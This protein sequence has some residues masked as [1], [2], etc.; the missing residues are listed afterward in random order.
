MKKGLIFFVV[1][2]IFAGYLFAGDGQ[3]SFPEYFMVI[4][5][6]L[7][8]SII[9]FVKQKVPKKWRWVIAYFL[10]ALVGVIGMFLNK[11][12]VLDFQDVQAFIGIGFLYTQLAYKLIWFKLDKEK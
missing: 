12:P 3:I 7:A 2:M 6:A 10:S 5:G 9:N 1:T 4:L 11:E 8:P